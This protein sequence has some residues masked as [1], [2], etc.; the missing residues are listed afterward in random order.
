M[1]TEICYCIGAM[2]EADYIITCC[3]VRMIVVADLFDYASVVA[4]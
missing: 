2:D 1:E 4:P 3:D